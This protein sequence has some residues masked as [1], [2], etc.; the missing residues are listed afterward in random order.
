MTEEQLNELE[1]QFL[2][3]EV[4]STM[5]S[6]RE[7]QMCK[8]MTTMIRFQYQEIFRLARIGLQEELRQMGL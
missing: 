4:K 6:E 2:E 7:R 5:D 8:T 1:K 3:V